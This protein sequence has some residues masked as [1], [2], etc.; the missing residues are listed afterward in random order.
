VFFARAD[1]TTLRLLYLSASAGS[2]QTP[3]GLL[4]PRTFGNR[5]D[6]ET[7]LARLEIALGHWEGAGG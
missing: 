5:P 4:P 2:I 6:D 3:L 7:G 1:G